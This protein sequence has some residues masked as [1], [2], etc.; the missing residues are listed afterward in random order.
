MT[1][2]PPDATSTVVVAATEIVRAR[3]PGLLTDLDD[4]RAALRD[5][6]PGERTAIDVVVGQLAA[7]PPGD[8]AQRLA[9]L[10]Q[11]VPD[12]H[13]RPTRT[14]EEDPPDGAP[15]PSGADGAASRRRSALLAFGGVLVLGSLA[16][17]GVA[18]ATHSPK[19]PAAAHP[20]TGTTSADAGNPAPTAAAVALH[21]A[22]TETT[23]PTWQCH[24][25]SQSEYVVGMR[26]AEACTLGSDGT[27]TALFTL[28]TSAWAEAR[29]TAAARRRVQALTG[30]ADEFWGVN[31]VICGT[32]L[33][34]PTSGRFALDGY[35][36]DAPYSYMIFA[37]DRRRA[38]QVWL[39]DNLFPLVIAALLPAAPA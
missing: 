12:P 39:D 22:F 9:S 27:V 23:S 28:W 29:N 6:L 37:P 7:V 19:P 5:V 14:A 24:Q 8:R 32:R 16:I 35:Y 36:A 13:L 1:A 20:A 15:A 4:L 11:V 2:Q 30:F 38:E 10:R 3:G 17:G 18:L 33:E 21:Q 34:Y 26:Y 31:R 25:A